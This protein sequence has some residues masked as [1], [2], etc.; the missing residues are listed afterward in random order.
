MITQKSLP[1]WY[2][3]GFYLQSASQNER[4]IFSQFKSTNAVLKRDLIKNFGYSIIRVI[5]VNHLDNLH[6][7]LYAFNIILFI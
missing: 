4:E 3:L 5:F 1:F 2:P 7:L 6:K